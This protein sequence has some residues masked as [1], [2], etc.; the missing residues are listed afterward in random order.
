MDEVWKQFDKNQQCLSLFVNWKKMTT[1]ETFISKSVPRIETYLT[2]M[3]NH[4]SFQFSGFWKNLSQSNHTV[5]P[6]PDCHEGDPEKETKC[7]S[8]LSQE[9]LERINQHFLF[10]LGVIGNRPKTCGK[11]FALGLLAGWILKPVQELVLLVTARAL[12]PSEFCDLRCL[13]I[14]QN[15]VFSLKQPEKSPV[16]M[17]EHLKRVNLNCSLVLQESW[18]C[19][20]KP[21]QGRLQPTWNQE[22]NT[23][24]FLYQVPTC[25]A[26]FSLM[27]WVK[28]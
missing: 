28:L 25:V 7:A 13:W 12:T 5:D 20:F 9:G 4:R 2:I 24:L 14:H 18:T 3:L 26:S 1:F 22:L 16:I 17:H 27:H 19:R 6:I 15:S 23:Q 10:N 11:G 21:A 8:E